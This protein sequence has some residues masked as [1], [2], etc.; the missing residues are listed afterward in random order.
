MYAE[1]SVS[2]L[3]GKLSSNATSIQAHPDRSRQQNSESRAKRSGNFTTQ[4][5]Q[6]S[7]TCFLFSAGS[8]CW[9][10]I[11]VWHEL[12]WWRR[13]SFMLLCWLTAILA[14]YDWL[15]LSMSLRVN[16]FC[17]GCVCNLR[18]VVLVI[19]VRLCLQFACGCVCNLCAVV[20]AICV[21]MCDCVCNLRAVVLLTWSHKWIFMFII[22]D[23]P[24]FFYTLDLPEFNIGFEDILQ[25]AWPH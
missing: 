22:P 2:I 12:S 6:Q 8:D 1:T 23:R 9:L 10:C 19:C 20:L 18:V 7:Q 21:F 24:T 3:C 11:L 17:Q 25:N 16:F 4:L 5:Q 14:C 13:S 15:S